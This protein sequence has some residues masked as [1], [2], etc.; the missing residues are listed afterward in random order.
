MNM[1]M[2]CV[3]THVLLES[4]GGTQVGICFV[5]ECWVAWTGNGM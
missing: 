2:G 1:G 5:G 3:A 4:Y